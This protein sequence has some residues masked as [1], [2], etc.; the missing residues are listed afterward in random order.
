MAAGSTSTPYVPSPEAK[1]L[2]A[3]H[4][5][6]AWMDQQAS[7]DAFDNNLLTFSSAAL[8]LSIAFIKDIVPLESAEWLKTLY[9]SWAAFAGCILVTIAS[10]QVA[11][12]AQL[13]QQKTLSDYYLL[14]DH[15]AIERKSRWSR[16][17]P[18]CAGI[19]SV[20]LLLGIVL[21]LVFASL[22]VSHY[23]ESKA[24]QTTTKQR[25]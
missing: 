8:G 16:A 25:K 17:L 18:I 4:I 5:A 3:K 20:F 14:G 6:Q 15:S 12:Q 23:K 19:G 9:F 24:W 2:H 10:F 1:E 13:A 11:V 22:N 21:T 7:T